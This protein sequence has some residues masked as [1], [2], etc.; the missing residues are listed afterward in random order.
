MKIKNL[1]IGIL[2][3][4]T[5]ILIY[6]II[7]PKK[8]YVEEKLDETLTPEIEEKFNNNINTLKIAADEYFK[9]N[10]ERIVTLKELK[11]KNIITELK[12]SRN[13]ECDDNSYVVKKDIT[14]VY[15]KCSDRE[16]KIN[17]EN[18]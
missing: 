7:F 14:T 6:E 11:E 8:S 12:D 13:E 16:K 3:I 4:L 15:L 10:N 2:L 17:I 1:F 5:I 18:D 9:D